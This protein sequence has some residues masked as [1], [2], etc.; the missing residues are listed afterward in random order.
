[1]SSEDITELLNR[2][3][4]LQLE[5]AR[6]ISILETTVNNNNNILASPSSG[7][8]TV[9]H[10]VPDEPNRYKKGDRVRINNKVIVSR[11]GLSLGR[12]ITEADRLAIVKSVSG[13]KVR[14]VTDNGTETW[15][16]TKNLD[17]VYDHHH[18]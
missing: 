1:M 7:T 8:T 3:K 12:T 14:I 18:E 10:R 6:I 5:Q 13:D 11:L 4:N 17:P 9:V 16:L 15:R 2:L